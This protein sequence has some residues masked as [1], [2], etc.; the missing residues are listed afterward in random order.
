MK[1][2]LMNSFSSSRKMS[3][4]AESTAGFD[5][6]FLVSLGGAA[7]VSVAQKM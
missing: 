5:A 4:K 3:E 1:K 2:D 6:L 7:E